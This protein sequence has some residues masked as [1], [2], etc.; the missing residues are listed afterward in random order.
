MHGYLFMMSTCSFFSYTPVYIV[1]PDGSLPS[2]LPV[3][4]ETL[5]MKIRDECYLLGKQICI[6]GLQLSN[7][8]VARLV[9]HAFE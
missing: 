8:E 4:L 2:I 7:P 3:S 6:W 5:L 1:R 9:S